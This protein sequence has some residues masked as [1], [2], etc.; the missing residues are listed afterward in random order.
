MDSIAAAL[1][2]TPPEEEVAKVDDEPVTAEAEAPETEEV[3]EA[4]ATTDD[5]D[6]GP[7]PE[8]QEPELLTVKVDGKELQVTLDELRRGYSGQ[9]YIQQRMKEVADARKEIDAYREAVAQERAYAAELVQRYQQSQS[10]QA[11]AK[12]SK[13]LLSSDPLR[14]HEEK[15][16]YDEW[17]EEQRDLEA[18][19]HFLTAKQAE[20]QAQ[21]E[22][23][24]LATEAQAMVAKIPE[25]AD[26]KK[27]PVLKKALIDTANRYGY[28]AEEVGSLMDH[29]AV[30]ILYRLH[31][32]ESKVAARP[33]ITAREKV[34][35]AGPV[36][37]PGNSRTTHDDRG[38]V[39]KK[40][41]DRMK[42]TGDIDDVARFL[43][44][45]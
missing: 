21:R 19:H 33:S 34:A 7:E 23:Q 17:V 44:T 4:E 26:P 2:T 15:A 18:Q 40:A 30:H 43:L 37:R 27:A 3:V 10:Q 28:T 13:D 11:P 29:R 16:L 12:P 9:A 5:E 25:M 31:E 6:D 45:S 8:A 42:Q 39:T 24:Y 41:R 36:L 38:L 14:Y 22:R 20:E 35:N 32:L 1:V